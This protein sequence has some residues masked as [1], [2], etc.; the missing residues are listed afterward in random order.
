MEIGSDIF[1]E[2]MGIGSLWG[3]LERLG[4]FGIDV[5]LEEDPGVLLPKFVAIVWCV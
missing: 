5:G 3:G 2:G 1:P 4:K